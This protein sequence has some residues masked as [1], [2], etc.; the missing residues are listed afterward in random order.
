[1]TE[2]S[3]LA[4]AELHENKGVA[5]AAAN[6]VATADGAGATVWQKI[7]SSN[8]DTGSIFTV[9]KEYIHCVIPDVSTADTTYVYVPFA[10]TLTLVGTV[11]ENT[12]TTA[13]STVTVYNH[14]GA[15]A[16]TIT[17]SYSGSAAGDIDSLSPVS[18][19]TFTAGQRLG[20]ATDGLSDTVAKLYVTLVFT[21]T[22]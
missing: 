19:N 8:I 6:T 16:G 9:N 2:H 22:G 20:I 4:E 14:A 7:T 13:D 18:N 3:A 12:I 21:V 5:A 17:I 10:G 1:M 11:L 15:S